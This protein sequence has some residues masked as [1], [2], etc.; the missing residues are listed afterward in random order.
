[1]KIKLLC[2]LLGTLM[3]LA[4]LAGCVQAP[5]QEE[6]QTQGDSDVVTEE[7]THWM[8]PDLDASKLSFNLEGKEV[9]I[10][11]YNQYDISPE[12]NSS[13][14]LEDAVYRR[15]DK[16]EAELG[17]EFNNI[18]QPDFN[19]IA[20][21]VKNDV[22]AGTGEFHIVYQH[23][24]DAARNLAPGDYLYNLT[25]LEHVD[26]DQTW[27]DQDCKNGF[28]IGDS[29]MMVCGDLLP[30]S[31]LITATVL[32]NKNLFEQNGWELPY[33]D[34]REGKW[35]MDDMLELTKDQ[36]KDL[37]GDGKIIYSDD[38]FGVTA[39]AADADF[40]LFFGSGATMFTYDEEHLP[41]F[42]PDTDRLQQIYEKI[43]E[44]LITQNSF[45]VIWAQYEKDPNMYHYTIDVFRDGRALFFPTYLSTTTS[46][47]DMVDDYG[48]LP[49]PK[50]DEKQENYL[51]FVNG[52]ASMAC[53]PSSLS[54]EGLELAGFMLETLASSSYYM[55][56]DTLYDV[57]A[58]SKNARDPES[59]EMVDII[60]RYKVFDFGYSHFSGQDMPCFNIA[61]TALQAN[62]TS[63]VR[64]ITSSERKTKTELKKILKSYGY[65]D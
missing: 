47:R 13:D 29:M 65:D 28:M 27:W 51:G 37:N 1:M 11:A 39:W 23:M 45:H 59:A 60:I 9:V 49:N 8:N 12:E 34:A 38:F 58:K 46:L 2:L 17:I 21:N 18:Y 48:I 4:A 40:N 30:S 41:V 43:Y 15:D 54:E 64:D 24:I 44:L 62:K 31:M 5:E 50:Y 36:T 6:D 22:T 7:E 55:T 19:V 16:L 63:I 56:T 25:E 33:D 35:T 10:L 42:E 61:Q 14:P 20:T 53:V 26:F 52:S 57:V 32:F 3:L